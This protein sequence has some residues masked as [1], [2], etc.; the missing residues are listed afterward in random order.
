MGGLETCHLLFIFVVGGCR[1]VVGRGR[2]K[3]LVIFCGHHKRMTPYS[4][5]IFYKGSIFFTLF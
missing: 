1:G 4:K 5:F 2:G 3:K